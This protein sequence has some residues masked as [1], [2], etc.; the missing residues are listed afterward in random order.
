V[1]EWRCLYPLRIGCV[2]Y[3]NARPLI[4]GYEGPVVF[5]HPSALARQIAAGDLDAGLIPVFEALQHPHY[6]LVDGVSIACD[7]PVYSVY[8]AHRGPLRGI[9]RV[10]LDGGSLTSVHLL[11][12]LLR[13]Y[14]GLQPTYVPAREAQGDNDAFLWIG[15]Q[16]IEFREKHAH[17]FEFLDL[18]AEWLRC[19][20]LPFVFAVWMLR[21]GVDG[22]GTLGDGF[23][24]LQLHGIA[25]LNEIIAREPLGTSEFRLRY[26]QSHIRYGLG[27]REKAAVAKFRL[28]LEQHGFI[29][30]KRE[31]LV[32]V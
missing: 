14:H 26:L 13:E 7:G 16:A 10:V 9:E 21:P 4:E 32:F 30:P 24:A 25:R 6:S 11:K 12:V 22:P 28:L 31:P 3:L 19:T 15:N 27:A 1:S 23:R 18:G 8:L 20:G 17:D 5:D 29:A 2:Q